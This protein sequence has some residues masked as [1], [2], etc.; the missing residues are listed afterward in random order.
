M[1]RSIQN[2]LFAAA[3]AAALLITGETRADINS[4]VVTETGDL[5]ITFD[6]IAI[7]LRSSPFA[8]QAE[9]MAIYACG[10]GASE[11]VHINLYTGR[12]FESNSTGRVLGMVT[13]HQPISQVQCAAPRLVYV[14]YT[15]VRILS[16]MGQPMIGRDVERAF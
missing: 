10:S 5:E 11:T 6:A 9:V 2:V 3:S 15:N 4:V 7:P 8:A 16:E 13:V 12:A 1:R 14:R